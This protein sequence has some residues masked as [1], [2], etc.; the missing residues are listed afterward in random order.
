MLTKQP[1]PPT[2]KGL[3]ENRAL[4]PEIVAALAITDAQARAKKAVSD[5]DQEWFIKQA[6]TWVRWLHA[7]NPQWRNKL[8]RESNN[9]RD[10]VSRFLNHWADAIVRNPSAYKKRHPLIAQ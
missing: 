10:F 8:D 2:P 4:S 7:N 3:F 1:K 5:Q 9:D 6:E